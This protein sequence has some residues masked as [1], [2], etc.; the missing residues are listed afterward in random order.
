MSEQ[1]GSQTC[2]LPPHMDLS[3]NITLRPQIFLGNI[4]PFAF[5]TADKDASMVSLSSLIKKKKQRNKAVWAVTAPGLLL[6]AARTSKMTCDTAHDI[7]HH[8]VTNDLGFLFHGRKPPHV[9]HL[10][11]CHRCPP[12]LPP[13]PQLTCGKDNLSVI[14][15]LIEL[16]DSF[17]DV[18]QGHGAGDW[19][20]A[21]P[22]G[23]A[24][25]VHLFHQVD[26]LPESSA[27]QAET[28]LLST[29]HQLVSGVILDSP[30]WNGVTFC[31]CA[32]C[33]SGLV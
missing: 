7:T 5:P 24:P 11:Q 15:L 3:T 6:P 19:W 31:I 32:Q 17:V 14:F 27:R 26:K 22:R 16:V 20:P 21:C 4:L 25:S 8:R 10:Y 30:A 1:N 28:W 18:L 2:A 29:L 33:V 23:F 13:P 9:V 12:P